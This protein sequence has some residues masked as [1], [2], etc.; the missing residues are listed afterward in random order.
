LQTRELLGAEDLKWGGLNLEAIGHTFVTDGWLQRVGVDLWSMSK[1]LA[2]VGI[3]FMFDTLEKRELQPIP[4]FVSNGKIGEDEIC[5]RSRP[6]QVGGAGDRNTGQYG[7][8][9]R[10]MHLA[11]RDRS[12]NLEAGIQHEGGIIGHGNID[13]VGKNPKLNNRWRIDRSPISG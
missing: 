7:N 11:I 13:I 2:K 8:V 3:S 5:G 6:V 10:C 4:P 1:R 12:G 9:G